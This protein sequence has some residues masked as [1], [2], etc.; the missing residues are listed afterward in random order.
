VRPEALLAFESRWP[1]H[2]SEKGERIRR[3][4]GITPARYYQLLIRAADSIEGIAA[5]PLTARRVR[6]VGAARAA[7]RARRTGMAA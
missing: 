1:G 3:E 2:S 5:E 4:L 6:E 7:A